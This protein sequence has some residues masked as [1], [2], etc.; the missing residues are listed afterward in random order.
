MTQRP[1]SIVVADDHPMVLQG[2]VGVLRLH[3][4]FDVVAV[5]D[6][7]LAALQAIRDYAPHVAVLDVTMPKMSGIDILSRINSEGYQTKVIFLSAAVSDK[8]IV[9]AFTEGVRGII[10]KDA[11]VDS[12]VTCIRE[13]AAGQKWIPA[14]IV[15]SALDREGGRQSLVELLTTREIQITSLISEGFSN[16]E[17]GRRLKLAEGTIKI[18]LHKIYAKMDV[19]NRTALTALALAH[20]DE[21]R[22]HL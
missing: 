17:I 9:T 10:F 18:H 7:G 13:V 11:A 14:D 16:K 4:D 5:C 8:E 20:K 19:P 1:I 21:L 6:E 15:E 22:S 12:I 2:V 3:K